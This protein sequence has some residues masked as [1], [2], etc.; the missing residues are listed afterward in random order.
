[1]RSS[2]TNRILC[3]ILDHKHMK[4]DSVVS[5]RRDL[6]IGDTVEGKVIIGKKQI[7]HASG[8]DQK[9]PDKKVSAVYHY[10]V[11][12]TSEVKV[13]KKKTRRA[14]DPGFTRVDMSTMET[15]SGPPMVTFRN[16]NR[17]G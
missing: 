8:M 13:T 6:A 15:V 16:V 1:M 14:K 3:E 2:L 17:L 11:E 7:V 9:D 5:S 4:T 10:E 12:S